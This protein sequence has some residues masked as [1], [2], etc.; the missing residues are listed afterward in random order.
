MNGIPF[1]T[2]VNE[3]MTVLVWVTPKLLEAIVIFLLGYLIMKVVLAVF[4][5]GLRVAKLNNIL[6]SFLGSIL[7]I[8]LWFLLVITVLHRIGL[9]SLANSISGV[10]A[11]FSLGIGLGAQHL[12]ADIISG[13]FLATERNFNLG[14]RVIAGSKQTE[15]TIEAMDFR[16]VRVRDNKS[17]LHTLPNSDV[18]KNQWTILERS[19]KV[20]ARK[21]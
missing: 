8:I 6:V 5:R 13:M 17:R 15:G 7:S 10:I 1:P 16:K 4:K 12:I 19:T 11:L 21:G 20:S 18:E 3:L 2:S 9:G 14:A